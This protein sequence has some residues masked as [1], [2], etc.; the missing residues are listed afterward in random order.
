[1]RRQLKIAIAALALMLLALTNVAKAEPLRIGYSDWPGFVPF[2]VALKKGFFEEV[3]VDVEMVWFEYGPSIDAFAAGQLDAV[4][5]AVFDALVLGSSGVPS[6]AAFLTDYSNGN[7]MIVARPGIDSM[8][9]LKG[10]KIGVETNLVE[11]LVLLKALELAGLTADDVELVHGATGE[12]PRVLA[13]GQVDAVAVWYPVGGQALAEVPGSK[14]VFTTREVP[15]LVFDALMVTPQ[16]LASRREDWVKV[17][18]AWFMGLDFIRDPATKDEA[19]QIMGARVN[20]TPEQ[21]EENLVGSDPLSLEDNV[22]H[23]R[24]AEGF[25]SV[26]GSA[27]HVDEFVRAQGLYSDPQDVSTYFDSNV[28]PDLLK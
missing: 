1:M 9:D 2:E 3:G 22:K 19:M 28:I 6:R 7:E 5:I 18:R 15:G 14:A 23:F 11:H 17:A 25:E 10:K 20:L 4:T 21:F 24:D 27:R 13:S 16:S 26:Y 8:A 12:L